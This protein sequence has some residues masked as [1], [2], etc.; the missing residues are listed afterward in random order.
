MHESKHVKKIALLIITLELAVVIF[1][2]SKKEGYF[3]DEISSY[4]LANSYFVRANSSIGIPYDEWIEPQYLSSLIVVSAEKRFEYKSVFFNQSNDVH[5][6]LYYILLHTI[7]SVFPDS[8]SKW[9]GLS[10]NFI[11]FALCSFFIY[12]ISKKIFTNQFITLLPSIVWGFSAGAISTAMF[13]R[14]YMLLTTLLVIYIY[15]NFV[16]IDS[17]ESIFPFI[18]TG[19]FTVLGFLTHYFFLAIAL[20]WSLFY[21]VYFLIQ[22]KRRL[23]LRYLLTMLNALLIG[24]LIFPSS[25]Y[26]ILNSY[27]GREVINNLTSFENYLER[28]IIMFDKLSLQLFGG[29]LQYLIIFVI[30]LLIISFLKKIISDQSDYIQRNVHNRFF[31]KYNLQYISNFYIDNIRLLSLTFSAILTFSVIVIASPYLATRYTYF[32][33]PVLSLLAVYYLYQIFS[34]YIINQ[35]NVILAVFTVYAVIISFSHYKNQIDH[36][37]IGYD[38]ILS[39]AQ[40]YSD[41]DCVYITEYDWKVYSNILE[42]AEFEKTFVLH[43]ADLSKIP[44]V[45]NDLKESEGIILYVESSLDQNDILETFL[46]LTNF[47]STELI[48]SYHYSMTYLVD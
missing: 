48:Y 42:L 26:H 43:P 45:L 36:L 38:D 2:G 16:L 1:F 3:L 22:K 40:E 24:V 4:N 33:Y 9:Y 25:I 28:L 32:I 41:L 31:K 44:R 10:L 17:E 27:R 13:I 20:F 14:M 11:L 21:M 39:T 29:F 8:F 6:P 5:P 18:Y 23:F 37:Y 47:D 12:L 19:I 46:P 30:C 7:C 15:T 35:R 34:L